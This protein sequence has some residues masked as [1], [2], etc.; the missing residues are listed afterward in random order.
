MEFSCI[1]QMADGMHPYEFLIFFIPI[2]FILINAKNI[3]TYEVYD[4]LSYLKKYFKL[5]I[6]TILNFK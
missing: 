5:Y 1:V 4:V 2:V 6:L 3:Y